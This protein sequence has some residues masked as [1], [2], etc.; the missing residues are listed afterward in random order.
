MSAT[1]NNF[2]FKTPTEFAAWTLGVRDDF[3]ENGIAK[4]KSREITA[5]QLEKK[6]AVTKDLLNAG[7]A[8]AKTLGFAA[9][10]P[11]LE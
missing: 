11:T 5:R 1:K 7:I 6:L 3:M 10:F 2:T 8:H 9:D 4:I